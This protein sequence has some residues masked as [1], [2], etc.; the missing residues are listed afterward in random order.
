M[1]DRDT[2]RNA[3]IEFFTNTPLPHGIRMNDSN[4]RWCGTCDMA[5]TPFKAIAVAIQKGKTAEKLISWK[6]RA[7][8]EC[9]SVWPEFSI[10]FAQ[11]MEYDPEFP[12]LIQEE[13]GT[14]SLND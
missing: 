11:R 8:P 9:H 6:E 13:F 2:I 10:E 3:M 14:Y 1:E 4:K 5:R 12:D 7:C